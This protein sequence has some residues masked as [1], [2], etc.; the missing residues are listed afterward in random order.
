[1]KLICNREGCKHA[2]VYK[3]KY[4]NTDKVRYTVC[5]LCKTSV[6]IKEVD[7]NG[8]MQPTREM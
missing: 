7:E 2:W 1:M 5:P 6:R 8:T 4:V 3:G